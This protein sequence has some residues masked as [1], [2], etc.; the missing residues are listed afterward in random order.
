MSKPS[1]NVRLSPALLNDI[2][3]LVKSGEYINRSDF[4]TRAI[5]E[6]VQ[7]DGMQKFIQEEI[8]KALKEEKEF[9]SRGLTLSLNSF[10]FCRVIAF[11]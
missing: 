5:I 11:I 8:K 3:K 10:A 1:I 6:L 7:R 9:I 4:V 2:D